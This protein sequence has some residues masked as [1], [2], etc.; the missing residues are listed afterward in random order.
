MPHPFFT[1]LAALLVA[2][3]MAAKGDLSARERFYAA[4]RVFC[5]CVVTVL[6]G[7]WVM[8]LVHG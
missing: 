5:C 2:L 3:A 7:S 4:L 8:R 1:L 6:A